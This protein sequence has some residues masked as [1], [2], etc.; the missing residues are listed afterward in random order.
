M[1]HMSRAGA[2][3]TAARS[4]PRWA[5][6]T[7]TST[8]YA[9]VTGLGKVRM[10]HFGPTAVPAASRTCQAAAEAAPPALK[11][12]WCP[13]ACLQ[14][15]P[16]SK[17]F[18]C[19]QHSVGDNFHVSE[20]AVKST[21]NNFQKD[22]SSWTHRG[23]QRGSSFRAS[24]SPDWPSP[25]QGLLCGMPSIRSLLTE[26]KAFSLDTNLLVYRKSL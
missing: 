14:P 19:F 12:C 2:P 11:R 6:I 23:R 22:L 13:A 17:R 5:S 20:H 21:A 24:C 4:C 10:E 1:H 25:A 15:L 26:H 3:R 8:S 7:P 18:Q 9:G 16:P